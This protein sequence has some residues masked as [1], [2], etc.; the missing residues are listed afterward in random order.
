MPKKQKKKAKVAL[1]NGVPKK[2]PPNLQKR[3][4]VQKKKKK[5]KVQHTKVP[6]LSLCQYS[7]F[8]AFYFFLIIIS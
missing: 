7:H 3:G 6:F 4:N 1:V 5:Q 2:L 8:L